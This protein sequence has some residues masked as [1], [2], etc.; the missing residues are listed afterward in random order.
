LEAAMDIP[1]I[2]TARLR[3]RPFWREDFPGFA[4][5]WQ[6]PEVVRFIGGAPRPVAE[7]WAAFLRIAGG[8]AMEGFGQWAIERKADGLLIGQTGFFTARRG[9]GEDFDSSPE[10]GWVLTTDAQ[11]QGLGP[12]AVAAAHL[13]FDGQPSG[14]RSCAMIEVGHGASFAVAER[15]GYRPMREILDKGDRVML[16]ERLAPSH[17]NSESGAKPEIRL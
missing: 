11:G 3:L 9:L 16:L 5:I 4:S 15:L 13:W 8:W 10:A 17:D 14:G 1:T 2:E 6:E 12:E 7:S